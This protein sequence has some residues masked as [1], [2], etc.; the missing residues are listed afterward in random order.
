MPTAT[1]LSVRG[2]SVPTNRA[3][4]LFTVGVLL[5]VGLRLPQ[6]MQ[7]SSVY[8]CLP[9]WQYKALSP[10][11]CSMWVCT[12]LIALVFMERLPRDCEGVRSR[13]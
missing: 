5:F 3:V 9:M 4:Q 7:R 6:W 10:A 13:G 12:L 8:A 2:H 1:P 11:Y